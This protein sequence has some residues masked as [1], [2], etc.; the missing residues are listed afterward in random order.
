VYRFAL[1]PRWILLHVLVLALIVTMIN[2]MFWQIR[3]LHEKQATNAKVAAEARRPAV[4]LSDAAAEVRADG[5]EA[6]HYRKVA[7]TGTFD[8]ADEITVPNRTFDGAPGRWVVTPFLPSDGGPAVLVVR[9]WIPLSIDD[10][11]PP[12]GA[13]APPKGELVIE[14]YVEPAQT[15]GSFGP[16]DPPRGR[17]SELSR[18]DVA[19]FAKQYRGDLAPGFFVQLSAQQPASPA[20]LLQP[21][22]RPAP[23]EG[24][25]RSY[26]WQWAIFTAIAI[27]GYP[28]ALRRQARS[29]DDQGGE[30]PDLGAAPLDEP[31]REES[32]REEAAR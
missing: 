32:G 23:D 15:R 27:V 20:A 2:L 12:I 8:V 9:G 11:H 16:T 31:A 10:D 14:G 5:A 18:V 25:H 1:R 24:P 29:A 7:D 4:L 19:R 17:L 30:D 3:R 26:A 6:I 22:P 28:L 21:V 13:V